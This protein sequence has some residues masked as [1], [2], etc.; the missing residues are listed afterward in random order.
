[1]KEPSRKGPHRGMN[2]FPPSTSQTASQHVKDPGTRG[3]RQ[4]D[5]G[6]KEDEKTLRVKHKRIVWIRGISVNDA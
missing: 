6:G 1:M 4:K 5:R 3:H 2:T